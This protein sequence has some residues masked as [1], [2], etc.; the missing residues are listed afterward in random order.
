MSYGKFTQSDVMDSPKPNELDG[1][2]EHQDWPDGRA[3]IIMTR[4]HSIH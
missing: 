3:I 2:A 4:I 1:V